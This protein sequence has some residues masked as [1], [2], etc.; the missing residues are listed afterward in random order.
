MLGKFFIAPRIILFIG[1]AEFV[2][3]NRGFQ[4]YTFYTS[5]EKTLDADTAVIFSNIV[6]WTPAPPQNHRIFFSQNSEAK[7][8]GTLRFDEVSLCGGAGV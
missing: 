3:L 1:A 6:I 2:V 5:P 8:E 7:R 4:L